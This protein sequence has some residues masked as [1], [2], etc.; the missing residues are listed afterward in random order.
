MGRRADDLIRQ[1]V[2]YCQRSG[3]THRD[4]LRLS[5]S[6][7]TVPE[8]RALFEWIVCSSLDEDTPELVC[9]S[10]ATQEATTVIAWVTLVREHR[11]IWEILPDAALR[12]PEVWEA[13]L[14]VGVP[15]VVLMC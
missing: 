7:T 8:P 15:Q 5:H 6:V 3:W 4:L 11:L 9:A 12:E 14:D 1:V 13:L 10:L 2:K